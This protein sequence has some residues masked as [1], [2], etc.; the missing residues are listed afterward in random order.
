MSARNYLYAP[1]EKRKL[2]SYSA[3]KAR[4]VKERKS[5]PKGRFYS[6][7]TACGTQSV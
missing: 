1:A 6:F 2:Y 4:G 5:P 3:R 7:Q